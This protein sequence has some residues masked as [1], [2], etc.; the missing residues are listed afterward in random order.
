MQKPHIVIISG[1]SGSGKSTALR[2]LEDMGFFC[3]DNL[4]T[5]L[6]PKF[7]ELCENSSS[8]INRIALVMDIREKGFLKEYPKL[9]EELRKKG[10]WIDFLFLEANNEIL[11]QRFSE[12]RRQHPLAPDSPVI[13]GIL[14]EREKMIELRAKAD[15][16]IDTTNLTVHQL[17][18]LIMEYFSQHST[19]K[20][21]ITFLSFGFKY[22]IPQDVDIIWDVRFLPNPYF[23]SE[24]K[25]L[26]G[27]DPR[28]VKYVL[29]C[30]ETRE[31]LEKIVD[32]IKFQIP[33]FER[34]GKSYLTIAIG[35]T[36]GRHRSVVIANFLKD[37]LD[38]EKYQIRLIHRDIDRG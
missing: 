22:G 35:C 24:L 21:I 14:R 3:V 11:I 30:K 10:H 17:R 38:K 4:P 27:N 37:I 19:R 1:L 31:F 13:E 9:L 8:E 28:V 34:E 29:D 6:L 36:G 18:Q 5:L 7:L 26:N 23:V 16:V 33:L 15:K 25:N 12:T 2:A 32:L 20:M